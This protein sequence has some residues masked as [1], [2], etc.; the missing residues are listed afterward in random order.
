MRGSYPNRINIPTEKFLHDLGA[1]EHG[2]IFCFSK[3]E[4]YNIHF[5]YVKSGLENNWGV[6]YVA[7]T[8]S[9]EVIRKAMQSHGINTLAYEN[10]GQGDGSLLLMSGEELYKNAEYPDTTHWK[11]SVRFVSDMFIS[12]GKKGVRVAADLSSYF[13]SKGLIHQWHKLEYILEKKLSLPVSVLCAYDSASPELVETDV[14][15]HYDRLTDTNKELINSHSFAIYAAG[16]KSIIF[17]V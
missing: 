6:V 10:N 4:M 11:N 8:G 12:K 2:C 3:E 7:A 15:K 17:R 9:K 13:L 1:G 14:L 5:S 16:N